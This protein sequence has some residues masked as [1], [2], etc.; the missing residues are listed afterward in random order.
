MVGL[1]NPTTK[2]E[3]KIAYIQETFVVNMLKCKKLNERF[4]IY[5]MVY[6]LKIP[7]LRDHN[8]IYAKFR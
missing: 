5:D 1:V 6:F 2:N 7:V 3:T 8:A 4:W